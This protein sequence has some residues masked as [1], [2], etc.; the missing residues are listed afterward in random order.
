MPWFKVDDHFWSHPKV[1]SLSNDAISLWVRAGSYAAQHLT[2]G[3]IP[4]A[5]VTRQ[6]WASLEH[7]GELVACGLWVQESGGYRFHDW[8][9]YQPTAE[10]TH[11]KRAAARERMRAFRE[12]KRAG[13]SDVRANNASTCAERSRE[14]RSTPNPNPNPYPN[15]STSDEVED[16]KP[17]KRGGRLPPDFAITDDMRQWARDT[18]PA[19]D[20][21][22]LLPEFVDY[23]AAQPGQKGVKT[24][25]VATWRNG[26]RKQSEWRGRGQQRRLTAAERNAAEY[27]AIYGGGSGRAGSVQALDL[28]ELEG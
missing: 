7:V 12:N 23:W 10:S 2:D 3:F 1:S 27:Q 8:F 24:D 18:V 9:E 25:W 15:P 16:N 5:T 4:D 21:D 11:A 14:V 19:L 13:S 28:G 20:V 6:L 22:E 17:R 26:M